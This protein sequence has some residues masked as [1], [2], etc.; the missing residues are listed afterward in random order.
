MAK[1]SVL[2]RKLI[3]F[4]ERDIHL[5]VQTTINPNPSSSKCNLFKDSLASP[6]SSFRFLRLLR[7]KWLNKETLWSHL[8][9]AFNTPSRTLPLFP[10][11]YHHR[12]LACNGF[13]YSQG[14]SNLVLSLLRRFRTRTSLL[15]TLC[16]CSN[17]VVLKWLGQLAGLEWS[18]ASLLQQCRVVKR[19]SK[20]PKDSPRSTQVKLWRLSV[21]WVL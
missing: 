2:S 13:W 15:N 10:P 3:K 7:L 11:T 12:R 6:L 17:L 14:P 19:L 1:F 21:V 20:P 18:L 16:K 9:L 5:L 8:L 4:K